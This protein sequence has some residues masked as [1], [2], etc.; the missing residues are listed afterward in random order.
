MTPQSDSRRGEREGSEAAQTEQRRAAARGRKGGH[1]PSCHPD[2]VAIETGPP[3]GFSNTVRRA[4]RQQELPA[5]GQG[6]G[7]RQRALP[8][9]RCALRA[10]GWGRRVPGSVQGRGPSSGHTGPPTGLSLARRAHL[11]KMA[12]HGC[13]WAGGWGTPGVG[14]GG[15]LVGAG[16]PLWG[17]GTLSL[18]APQSRGLRLPLEH[19]EVAL[20]IWKQGHDK[21]FTNETTESKGTTPRKRPARHPVGLQAAKAANRRVPAIRCSGKG[22]LRGQ[23]TTVAGQGAGSSLS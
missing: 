2:S 7:E 22:R 14:A 23:E 15:P 11:P 4:E 6:C 17:W 21:A 13:R 8:R 3:L 12:G 10:R 18:S 16:G 20:S 1:D 5:T 19:G 9:E